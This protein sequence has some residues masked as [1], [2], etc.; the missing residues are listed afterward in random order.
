MAPCPDE[1]TIAAFVARELPPAERESVQEHCQACSACQETVSHLVR[2][3]SPGPP[4]V[5]E[6]GGAELGAGTELPRGA[7]IGRYLVL[8]PLGQGAVGVVYAAYDPELDRRLALKLLQPRRAAA[9]PAG[10]RARLV[11]EARAL[12]SISHPNVVAIHDVGTHRDEVFI[13]M[14]LVQ[15]TTLA[16]W[17]R[18]ATRLRN[19]ASHSSQLYGVSPV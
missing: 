7:E 5:T 16:Q 2:A 19:L 17:L 11:R 3:F 6:P 1:E 14:E 18:T 13:A 10:W 15:G 12:A 4:S 8:E 9:D